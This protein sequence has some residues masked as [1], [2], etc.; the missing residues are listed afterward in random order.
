[1]ITLWLPFPPSA[2]SLFAGKTRRYVSPRYKKWRAAAGWELQ[3][4]RIRSAIG[5]VVIDIALTAP[6]KRA[7]D[8][9]NG[10]K[11][12]LDLLVRHGVLSDDS[13]VQVRQVTARWTVADR[14]GATI[15][16]LPA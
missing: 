1:M 8:A 11:A 6:D 5:P 9:D 10:N 14:P 3:S 13:S 16:I 15:T 12:I 7:R 2:N 4:Q